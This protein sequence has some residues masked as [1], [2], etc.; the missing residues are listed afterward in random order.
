MKK[1]IIS[2]LLVFTVA[3][4]VNISVAP[5]NYRLDMEPDSNIRRTFTVTNKGKEAISVRVYLNDWNLKGSEK[6]FLPA[7]ST[8]YTLLNAV[9]FYP[10]LLQLK[11]GE[12]KQVM[13]NV[14]ALKTDTAGEYGVLFFEA[15]P[16][17]EP[18]GS[19]LSLGG[20]IGS[21]LYKEIPERSLVTY[22]VTGVAASVVGN[23]LNYKF[24]LLNDGNVLVRPKL[25]I[26]VLDSNNEVVAKKVASDLVTLPGKQRVESDQFILSSFALASK[27]LT[28]ILTLDFGNNLV[29]MEEIKV[30]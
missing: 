24:N 5:S 2:L 21:I 12:T 20:R 30:K 8:E 1:L 7:G 28:F 14:K 27:D 3:F 9:T 22:K 13:M 26:I 16:V 19:G 23:K 4:A 10:S 15:R 17:Q 18:K 11:P 29:F 25:T 6:I